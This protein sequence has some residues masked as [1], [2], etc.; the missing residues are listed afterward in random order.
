L[1]ALT[2]THALRSFRVRRRDTFLRWLLSFAGDARPV[3]PPE[4]VTEWR[5]LLTSAR[6]AQ[7][8]MTTTGD[9]A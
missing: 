9:A 3:S 4:A 2:A 1:Q 6:A 5:A 8:G 7:Q